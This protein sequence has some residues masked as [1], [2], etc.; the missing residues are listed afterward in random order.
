VSDL[1][2]EDKTGKP[3]FTIV[4]FGP[5]TRIANR[6]TEGAKKYERDNYKCCTL[7]QLQT[8]RESALRHLMQYVDGQDSEDHLSAAAVN[9]MILMYVEDKYKEK[10]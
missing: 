7:D 1:L 2:R 6:F 3:D 8:Y 9:I 5:L 10:E 4:P